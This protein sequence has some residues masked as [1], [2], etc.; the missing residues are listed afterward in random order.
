[1]ARSG[2]Y[3]VYC[4]DA[5]N[6]DARPS[7]PSPKWFLNTLQ[8]A[9]NI[10]L[11]QTAKTTVEAIASIVSHLNHPVILLD[12]YELLAP[13]DNWFRQEFLPQLPAQTLI[14][15]ASRHSPA[16]A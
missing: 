3:G 1:M 5:Q 16:L 6:L 2:H 9:L 15:L 10:N 4:L 13:L 8:S 12:N 7:K 11:N 14:V